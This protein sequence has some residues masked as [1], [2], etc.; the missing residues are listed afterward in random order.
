MFQNKI[1]PIHVVSATPAARAS[2]SHF[3]CVLQGAVIRNYDDGPSNNPHLLFS[4][5]RMVEMSQ[6]KGGRTGV[7]CAERGRQHLPQLSRQRRLMLNCS[8]KGAVKPIPTVGG[9]PF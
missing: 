8:A 5:D 9:D 3:E 1:R 7:V 4:E 2:M 6:T